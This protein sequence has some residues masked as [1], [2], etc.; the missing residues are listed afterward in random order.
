MPVELTVVGSINLDLV[1]RVERLPRA[2]ETVAGRD[3]VRVPGG[4]GANQ[5]VAAARLGARVRMV[6]AVGEDPLADEALRGLVDAGVE[7]HLTRTGTTGIALILVD[8]TGENQIVVVP[9]A[10]AEVRP[11]S[12]GGAVLCQLEVPDG[13]VEAAAQDA[14]FFALN[15]APARPVG[16][17]P[18]LLIVNELEHEVVS[19]GKLVAVTYGA[20][21]A[22]LFENGVEVARRMPRR[23][24]PRGARP[25]RG[26][27]PRLRRRRGRCLALRGATFAPHRRRGRSDTRGMT[28]TPIILDC[29]PGHDDAIAIL[30]AV[31]SPE[32]ELRAVT[33]V[34][35]NQTLD[36]T[37]NNAL[38]V[39]EL[40]G[41]S[42]IP[43]YAGADAPF[44]RQRDV[45]AHVHGE[46]G[47]DGP[48][49][50]PPTQSARAEHAV[51]F[52]ARQYR[53][54][55]KPVLVAT[56]PL[57]NVGL[58][59]ATHAGARPERI[60]LMGGAI[61]EG[62]RTPA[63]EF[64]IW[65][66]PEAAQRVF[67][68]ALDTTMVGLD[69]THRA[70]IKDEHTERMRAAGRVGKVVAE[71]MDFY[72][73]FHKRRYTD[74]EG[75]PMH[76]PVCVAHLIDPTLMDVRDAYIEVDCTTGPSWGRTNVDWRGRE[77]FG[78]PNAKVGL[79]IDGERFA[80]LVV[81]RISSLDA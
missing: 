42:D 69:V 53:S 9:G 4:K 61:G 51:E 30:L 6:G 80:E 63:A 17:E 18:D 55:E 8:D 52:L 38:R 20:V 14:A 60:V 21:G 59:F 71:L 74:L 75:S 76:D 50:P 33:T 48:D 56:G 73:R 62:N 78:A 35:G 2:G 54:A 46:S 81:E 10:N 12:L 23:L 27:D 68:E 66:D 3:F 39:L 32:L 15:A 24:A 45:A 49:L 1:A 16:L 34:S 25:R 77:H 13:V 36:K 64:N 7:L 28:P 79:D 43:V 44:V 37:T 72:A 41:R 26:V 29:D 67:G 11:V 5:A 58:L 70:L 22:A 31:A 19:R 47:L 65:A 57:T 40:A